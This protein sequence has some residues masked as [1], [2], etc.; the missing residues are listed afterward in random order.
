MCVCPTW[1]AGSTCSERI[2]PCASEKACA[3]NGTCLV[4]LDVKPFGYKCKCLPGFIG[5]VC[6]TNVDDCSSQPCKHGRCLDKANGFM[7]RCYEGYE[8][9]FCDVSFMIVIFIKKYY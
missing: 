6:E 7:C 8:G 2:N 5:E 4:D 3:N 9:G 1:F